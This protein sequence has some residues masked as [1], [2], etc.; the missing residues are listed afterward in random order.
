MRASRVSKYTGD[1]FVTRK[2]RRMH[3]RQFLLPR[4]KSRFGVKRRRAKAIRGPS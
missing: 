2:E 1:T 4:N 3:D